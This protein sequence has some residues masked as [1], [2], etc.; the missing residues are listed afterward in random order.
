MIEL[1]I[2]GNSAIN[3]QST[4]TSGAAFILAGCT[5]IEWNA[6]RKMEN[7]YG[8]G[9][10][11]RGRGF[12][13][14]EYTA[15]IELPYSSQILLRSKS[16]NGSLIGLGE[17]NLKISFSNDLYQNATKEVV[18]LAGCL[19]TE[20]GF[21]AKQDDTSLNHKFDLNP[22]RIYTDEAAKSS[23]WSMELYSK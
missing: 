4:A 11:S 19:F 16:P 15:A 1:A 21:E 9:G 10:Q 12:G 7:I 20:D 6:K 14:V 2:A 13:N 8:L 23:T 18:T 17:F 5:A 3:E 22:Y